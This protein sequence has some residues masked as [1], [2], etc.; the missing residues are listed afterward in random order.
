[1]LSPHPC[2]VTFVF[3]Q[4][5]SPEYCCI[6]KREGDGSGG[7]VWVLETFIKIDFMGNSVV[8]FWFHISPG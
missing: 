8:F 5:V 7:K 3:A 2:K 6:Q 1:M 4:E